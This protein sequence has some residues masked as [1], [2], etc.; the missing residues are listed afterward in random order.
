MSTLCF[1]ERNNNNFNSFNKKTFEI[2]SSCNNYFSSDTFCN[3]L[4]INDTCN[5]IKNNSSTKMYSKDYVEELKRLFNKEKSELE[6]K[7][8]LLQGNI[9][10]IKGTFQEQI[11]NFHNSNQ[12]NLEKNKLCLEHNLKLKKNDEDCI[13]KKINQLIEE[14]QNLEK[15]NNLLKSSLEEQEKLKNE[16]NNRYNLQIKNLMDEV[17]KLK[18]SMEESKLNLK[19]TSNESL[20]NINHEIQLMNQ[21]FSL[22]YKE[23]KKRIKRKKIKT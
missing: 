20:N 13:D 2:N 4:T 3:Q 8:N 22:E 12:I 5:G 1:D 19:N 21:K 23:K 17:N 15:Q 16:N 10:N 14:N 18:N 11:N 9:D 6:Y 7:I